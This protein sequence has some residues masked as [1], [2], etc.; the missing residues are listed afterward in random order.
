MDVPRLVSTNTHII[1]QYAYLAFAYFNGENHPLKFR[2]LEI[3]H[4]V[5]L[6]FILENIY[7]DNRRVVKIYYRPPSIDNKEKIQLNKFK[8]KTD[9]DLTIM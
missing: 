1:S 4:I 2:F 9:E 5:D 7:P 6:K 3:T 8:L